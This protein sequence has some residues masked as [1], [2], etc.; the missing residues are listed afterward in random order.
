MH[1]GAQTYIVTDL[2]QTALSTGFGTIINQGWSTVSLY[3]VTNSSWQ[4]QWNV[5]GWGG[6]MTVD[7]YY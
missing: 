3:P 4:A 5:H 2:S 7:C 1:I 6:F